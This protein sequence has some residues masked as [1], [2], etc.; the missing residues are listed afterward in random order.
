MK[1]SIGIV[2][3]NYFGKE[4]TFELVESL[5]PLFKHFNLKIYIVNNSVTESLDVLFE[6]VTNCEV[7]NLN[8]NSGFSGGCNYGI[9]KALSDGC[10]YILLI[11][12][13]TIA[14]D[15][16]LEPMLDLFK[17]DENLGI[18]GNKVIS[19]KE[20]TII[21]NGGLLFK[22]LVL[23]TNGLSMF[24]RFLERNRSSFFKN[25]IFGFQSGCCQ[26][27][28]SL[29]FNEG[30]FYDEDYFLYL[31]DVDFC[32]RV[33]Q[34]GYKIKFAS[35]SFIYHKLNYSTGTK[36]DLAYYYGTRNKIHFVKKHFDGSLMRFCFLVYYFLNRVVVSL[37]RP[38]K[39]LPIFSG[40]MHGI[41]NISGVNPNLINEDHRT[42]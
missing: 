2:T 10:K 42:A 39:F 23:I 31:E 36:S 41:K 27:I 4:A 30:I 34:A 1:D 28:S 5:L 35:D 24:H 11:N 32:Y 15:N 26:L 25:E 20:N 9:R 16:F 3:I 33:Q 7:L 12:N 37:S 21:S 40:Y 19:A 14:N 6:N 13:D 29:V 22:P 18:V 17:K 38:S 8:Y